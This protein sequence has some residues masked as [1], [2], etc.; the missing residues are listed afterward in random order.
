MKLFIADIVLGIQ[1]EKKVNFGYT[2]ALIPCTDTKDFIQEFDFD[3][4]VW[5]F[6]AQVR[7]TDL[8]KFKSFS[9]KDL[10]LIGQFVWQRYAKVVRSQNF[11]R[12]FYRCL[13]SYSM[14]NFIKISCQIKK[15]SIQKHYFDS[16]VCMTAICYSV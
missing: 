15:F 13:V 6:Y 3:S 4:S 2:E 16:S 10:S 8:V 11:L 1:N 5:Q 12:T 14:S 7:G 9:Y